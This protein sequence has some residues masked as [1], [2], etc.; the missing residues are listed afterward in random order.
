MKNNQH[1]RSVKEVAATGNAIDYSR[2]EHGQVF[3][4]DGSTVE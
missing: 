3:P 2:P 1:Q 4:I